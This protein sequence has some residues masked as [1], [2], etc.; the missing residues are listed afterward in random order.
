MRWVQHIHLGGPA[1]FCTWQQGRGPKPATL[2]TSCIRFAPCSFGSWALPRLS[3]ADKKSR[4]VFW[5]QT[6]NYLWRLKAKFYLQHSA[7][8]I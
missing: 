2:S 7:D 6:E 4:N 5:S 8:L 1:V 3:Q